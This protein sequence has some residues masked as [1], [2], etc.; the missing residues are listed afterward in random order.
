MNDVNNQKFIILP[1][2]HNKVSTA[3]KLASHFEK[4]HTVVFLGDFFDNWNDTRYDAEKTARWLKHSLQQ[5]NRIHIGGNHDRSYVYPYHNALN[6]PGYTGEKNRAI[7]SILTQPEL[8]SLQLYHYIEEG[9]WMLSHAGFTYSNLFGF[10]HNLLAKPGAKYGHVVGFSKEELL[11]YLKTEEKDFIEA[12]HNNKWHHFMF[13]GTRMG[14]DGCGGPF[15]LHLTDF[16][17]IKQWNQV[18]A[19][20]PLKKPASCHLP[21]KKN[22]ISTNWCIDTSLSHFAILEEGFLSFEETKNVL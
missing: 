5:P 19:H 8:E 4:T 7:R 14:N 15:W 1:D 17:P 22:P 13:Q 18:F 16:Y 9:N 11:D 2:I 10:K 20:T 6:C 21:N 12:C 3:E